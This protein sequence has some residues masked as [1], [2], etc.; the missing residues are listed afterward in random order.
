M[1]ST[2][3]TSAPLNADE[4]IRLAGWYETPARRHAVLAADIAP[5]PVA[6]RPPRSVERRQKVLA[7]WLRITP[8]TPVAVPP[9]PNRWPH[10]A[11][12]RP[13]LPHD[14]LPPPKPARRTPRHRTLA[15]HRPLSSPNCPPTSALPS[16]NTPNPSSPA[17]PANFA[18]INWLS[19][20][21]NSPPS[22]TPTGRSATPTA[23]RGAGLPGAARTPAG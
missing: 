4:L 12:R 22:S 8:P 23:R 3:P 7:D 6:A 16:V 5:K 15:R 20:P 11:P 18:P 2:P 9:W 13:T 14:A 10:A 1:R 21:P 19:W 17:T